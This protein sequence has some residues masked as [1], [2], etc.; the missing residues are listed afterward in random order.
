MNKLG[1][2]YIKAVAGEVVK[3]YKLGRSDTKPLNIKSNEESYRVFSAQWVYWILTGF[4]LS[5]GNRSII[6][7]SGSTVM[8]IGCR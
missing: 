7:T 4:V 3:S 5:P 6:F 1:I 2:Q 8:V